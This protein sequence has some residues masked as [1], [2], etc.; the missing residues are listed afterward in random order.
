MSV[1]ASESRL[2]EWLRVLGAEEY[3]SSFARAG[4]DLEFIAK[5]GLQDEDLDCVGIPHSKLGLR[6][7]LLSRH[8]IEDFIELDEEEGE[9]EDEESEEEADD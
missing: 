2:S 6:R 8:K 3:F 5:E 4:Y 7:K 1:D 9:E